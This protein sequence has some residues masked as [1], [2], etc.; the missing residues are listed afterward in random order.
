MVTL[1]NFRSRLQNK[2]FDSSISRDVT[3]NKLTTSTD[4]WGDDTVTSTVGTSVKAVLY[5]YLGARKAFES[6]GDLKDTETV[7]VF[8]YDTDIKPDYDD[9]NTKYQVVANSSTFN[10][11]EVV[12]YPYGTGNLAY[13]VRLARNV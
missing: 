8:P 12:E 5:D 13:A 10:V 6:W 1:E 11:V 3:V 9:A 4:K 7:A 2:L